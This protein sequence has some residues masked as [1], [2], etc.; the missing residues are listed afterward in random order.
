MR[1]D[2]AGKIAQVPLAGSVGARTAN[3]VLAVRGWKREEKHVNG[4]DWIG[5]FG[6]S[7]RAFESV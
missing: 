1:M 6:E 3:V 5:A 4:K 2:S 7:E